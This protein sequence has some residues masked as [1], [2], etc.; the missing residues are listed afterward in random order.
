MTDSKIALL[1]F[2]Q[3]PLISSGK[4]SISVMTIPRAG[5]LLS[6]KRKVGK[7][8]LPFLPRL[9]PLHLWKN[10]CLVYSI[11][12]VIGI[13]IILQT[14]EASV[15][16]PE[17]LAVSLKTCFLFSSKWR[18]HDQTNEIISLIDHL[19]KL[20]EWFCLSSETL[21][22]YVF[23]QRLGFIQFS[24]LKRRLGSGTGREQQYSLCSLSFRLCHFWSSSLSDF[25]CHCALTLRVL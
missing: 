24:P 16:R 7:T 5:T 10:F 11:S 17:R 13:N 20:K 21:S 3:G 4:S 14:L 8:F 23:P 9:A 1:I 22:I 2:N 19:K 18:M 6:W 25:T 15:C 12:N